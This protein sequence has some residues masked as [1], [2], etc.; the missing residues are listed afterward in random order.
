MAQSIGIP[1]SELESA[2]TDELAKNTKL[3]QLAGGNT[4]AARGLAELASPNTKMT[5]EG[6]LRVT[7]QLIGQE[8]YNAAKANFMQAATG[9]PAAYQNKLLQ[10]QNAADPRFFQEM[11]QADAQ[12]MMQA[13]S[14][15]EL[16]ALRQ[17]RA[18]AKQLGI[19]R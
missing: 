4:D 9:D 5:K 1:Y 7:N 8:Q 18:L 19:I 13:M 6:M 10:W 11:S 15:A 16:A 17:K 3:L 12:K 2:S 14:P